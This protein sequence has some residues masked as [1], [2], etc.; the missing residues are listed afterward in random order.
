VIRRVGAYAKLVANYYLD[1]AVIAAGEAAELLF[2]RTNAFSSTSD[3][4]GYHTEAQLLRGPAG[5]MKDAKKRIARLVEVGLW[6]EVDGGYQVRSWVKIH[7]S[8]EEKGRVKKADRDRKRVDL[9]FDFPTDSGRNPNGAQPDSLSLIQSSAVQSSAVSKTRA[10]GTRIDDWKP[11]PSDIDWQRRA[12][13]ADDIARREFEKFG[14]YWR[15][16]PGQ[17]GLKLDWSATWRNWLRTA[18]ERAVPQ[19]ETEAQARIAA[20]AA[21]PLASAR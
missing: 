11:G 4:D 5:G 8:S 20:R 9:P 21:D 14:D 15:A 6:Q 13:I 19:R 1:D 18:Q 16:V 17:R 10:R 7:P 2:V 12:S 3:S